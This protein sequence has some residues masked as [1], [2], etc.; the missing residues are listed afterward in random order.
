MSAYTTLIIWDFWSKNPC[1]KRS[2][3]PTLKSA[4]FVSDVES[5]ARASKF[6]RFP[7]K[8]GRRSPCADSVFCPEKQ[9]NSS[10]LSLSPFVTARFLGA[11]VRKSGPSSG[12]RS[13]QGF[14]RPDRPPRTW[15]GARQPAEVLPRNTS[16]CRISHRRCHRCLTRQPAE[17]PGWNRSS[18]TSLRRPTPIPS[19]HRLLL[20]SQ[21]G[22]FFA[23]KRLST[24]SPLR[25]RFVTALFGAEKCAKAPQFPRGH[26]S[27]QV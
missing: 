21:N 9:A 20:P 5:G 3:R 11:K 6:A 23:Q 15:L 13:P 19:H 22:L 4:F 1:K 16:A 14:P 8:T 24:M 2:K 26:G 27:L 18:Q 17:V 7:P 10:P 12:P 25:H